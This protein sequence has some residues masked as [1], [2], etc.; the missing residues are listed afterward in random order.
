MTKHT[1]SILMQWGGQAALQSAQV[2]FT[3]NTAFD[4]WQ[5]GANAPGPGSGA[6]LTWDG[7]GS[8]PEGWTA[9]RDPDG[10][11][12]AAV[13]ATIGQELW[14]T[15]KPLYPRPQDWEE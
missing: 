14:D 9:S 2:D 10:E 13:V 12:E 7:V 11:Y 1:N 6:P 3:N 4:F 5:L 15:L 8:R